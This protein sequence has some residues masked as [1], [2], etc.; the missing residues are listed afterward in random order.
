MLEEANEP[1]PGILHRCEYYGCPECPTVTPT[2]DFRPK[3]S[4]VSPRFDSAILSEEEKRRISTLEN[5]LLALKQQLLQI[6]KLRE[7]DKQ[8]S[9]KP[10]S[11]PPPEPSAKSFIP[12]PPPLPPPLPPPPPP[13]PK[14]SVANSGKS[15]SADPQTSNPAPAPSMKD[16][17]K[18]LSLVKLRPIDLA[19]WEYFKIF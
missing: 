10:Q 16:V 14:L 15:I 5:E 7:C 17:L 8:S 1:E 11:S 2:S 12:M 18:D 4:R 19:K 6:T 3:I 9:G 13:I